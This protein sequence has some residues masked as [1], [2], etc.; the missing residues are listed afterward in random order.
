MP[1]IASLTSSDQSS[2]KA[3]PANDKSN[4]HTGDVLNTEKSSSGLHIQAKLTVGSPDDP[5]EREA[6]SVAEKVM[7]MPER[8]FVQRKCAECEKEEKIQRKA[9]AQAN[10]GTQVN[11]NTANSI[12]SSRGKGDTMD[13]ATQ[14]V[15]NSSSQ[16]VQ[17]APT[18][19]ST[20]PATTTTTAEATESD[21]REFVN[22]AILFLQSSADY[23]RLAVVDSAGLEKTLSSLIRMATIYP[24]LIATRLNNDTTLVQAFQQA[25]NN[26]VRVI[27]T[28]Y[29]SVPANNTS[30][31]NLYLSNLYRLPEWSRPNVTSF[32]L[33]DDTQRRHF[34]TEYTTALNNVSLFQGVSAITTAQL[35]SLLGY[36]YTLTADTQ[37]MLATNLNND[38]TLL[39][40]LRPAYSAAIKNLLSTAASFLTGETV[41]TLFIRYRYQRS[42][43]IHE[44][45]DQQ[46][47][48]TTVAVPLGVSPDPLT[49]NTSFSLNGYNVTIRSDGRQTDAGAT[50][51]GDFAPLNIPYEFN[52]ANNRITSF[53]PPPSP[54]ITIWTDYGPGT[55]SGISSGYGRGTTVEDKRLGNTTLGYHERSHSRDFLSFMANTVAPTFSGTVGMTVTQFSAAVTAY[56]NALARMVRASELATDC[57]GTPNIVQ[58]HREHHTTT[59]VVCP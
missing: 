10:S 39:A 37:N 47:A 38:A 52:T 58:Y 16:L 51:H 57:V 56:R 31:V 33:K 30:V 46:L 8:N 19:P 40:A 28:K 55:N 1:E 12:H 15:S 50:T 3:S 20:M 45:A 36:L 18:T 53:T 59:T 9:V 2:A 41:F 7:R 29:A 48:G 26:E 27:F 22:D 14:D 6:D 4:I 54:A 25:F 49:G 11:S 24:N 23:Y 21:I 13:S 43:L 32:N 5:L 34:V 35:E 17:R 44:W 42:N